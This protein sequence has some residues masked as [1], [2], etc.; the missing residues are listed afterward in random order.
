MKY[1]V[2]KTGGNQY[3]VKSGDEIW[4]D[5]ISQETGSELELDTLMKFEEDEV[6]LGKPLLKSATKVKIIDHQ[7]AD[8][9]RVSRFKAKSR[10]DKTVG[11][12]HAMTKI[13]II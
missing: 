4:V 13:K 1:S 2:V 5:R 3:L 10:Y 8:K 9:I 11:F 6:E 12:R 7:K